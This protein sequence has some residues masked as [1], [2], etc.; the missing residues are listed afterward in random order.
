MI[1]PECLLDVSGQ[2]GMHAPGRSSRPV[3]ILALECA[4]PLAG[5]LRLDLK[6]PDAVTVGRAEHGA[7]ER[8]ET[9]GELCLR[10]AVADRG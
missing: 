10:I 8:L 2:A 6:G 3:L 1:A 4:R 9:S 5:S 7:H